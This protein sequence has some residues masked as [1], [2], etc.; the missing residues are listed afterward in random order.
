MRKLLSMLLCLCL[1]TAALPAQKAQAEEYRPA[2]EPVTETIRPGKATLLAFTVPESGPVSLR[3]VS[4]AGETVS[5][6]VEDYWATVGRNE[7]WWNGTYESVFAPVGTWQL[8]LTAG[9]GV[10]STT[11]TVGAAAPYL[12]NIMSGVELTSRT[13]TVSFYASVDGLLSVG[14]VVNG[15]WSLIDSKDITAGENV[16]VWDMS[17]A[18]AAT[19]ALTLTLTDA[20]GYPSN[21]E[22]ITVSPEDFPAEESNA[23]LEPLIVE[24]PTGEPVIEEPVIEEPVIEEPVIEEPTEASAPEETIAGLPE[25][26]E[27]M[28]D[29]PV[30]DQ[31]VY[32]PTHGSPFEGQD[33]SLNYWTMPMDIT[34]EETIWNV[35][36]QPMT[37]LYSNKDKADRTQV[38]IRKEPNENSQGIGVVT[39]INQGVHVL[40]TL[41]NGWSLIECYSSSFHDSAVQAWNLLVQ[42]Y[43]KSDQL[44]TVEPQTQY[45]IVIDK[46][47]QRL[48]LFKEGH[49]FTTLLVSTGL[50]NASQPW[51]ETRSGEFFLTSAVG[52]FRD[53]NLTFDMA[54]R[55]NSG[56][57][58]HEIPHQKNAD[59]TRRYGYGMSDLGSKASHGCIR[60]QRYRSPEGVNMSWLWSNRVKNTKLII[61]EDWQGRQIPYPDNDLTLY[62]NPNGGTMYHSAETCYSA[63]GKVF[64]PFTYGELELSPFD[65]LERCAYCAPALRHAEIDAINANY[66]PGGDHDPILTEARK[67]YFNSLEK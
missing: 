56:D 19:T 40:E 66:L 63:S 7:L 49:L 36:M 42:G 11:V 28:M 62:Y 13:M 47:T 65:A 29:E 18:S 1:L 45:G 10:V 25:V 33:T 53:G 57:L 24:E 61:W 39:R 31:T 41:D 34:D 22:H 21:E 8:E 38:I 30:L 58:I 54:I 44:R 51:N 59:G 20:Q 23:T 2:V 32:T 52:A 55:F 6:V 27:V 16:Y 64:T 67:K 5:V 35:L 15:A 17:A 12:T 46:L 48:Y 37:I 60:V 26:D 43:V 9:E 50:T 14:A 4:G 3:L